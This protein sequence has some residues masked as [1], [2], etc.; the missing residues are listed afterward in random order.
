M[1]ESE[2]LQTFPGNGD[3]STPCNR[4]RQAEDLRYFIGDAIAQVGLD[5]DRTQ[6]C[7]KALS[8]CNRTAEV[9]GSI[10]LSST[11]PS[12]RVKLITR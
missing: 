12:P 11:S 2:P 10:P 8:L 4:F 9:M 6:Y 7:E 1:T 5:P 3:T